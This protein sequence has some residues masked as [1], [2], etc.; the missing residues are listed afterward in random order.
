[1][2][3]WIITLILSFPASLAC[4]AD[5]PMTGN[6][7]LP[8]RTFGVQGHFGRHSEGW[9]IEK[10]L[11]IM[12]QMG[13]SCVKDEIYWSMVEKR[14]GVYEIDEANEKFVN[15]LRAAG[16][17][18]IFSLTY[19]NSLYADSLDAD[20]YAN[21]CRFM[22]SH[23]KGRVDIW[24]IW[25][26]PNNFEFKARYGGE[27]NGKNDSPWI[28]KFAIL[29]EK[30][31]RAIRK[32]NP[33]A[34]IITSAGN[35]PATH[36]LVTRFAS[37]LQD[38]DGLA[39]HP[40]PMRLPP[41]TLPYGGKEVNLRDGIVTADDDHS[42][43][44]TMR[45]LR[46]LGT[47]IRKDPSIWITE[48]GYTTYNQTRGT[49]PLFYGFTPEAQAAYLVR[50]V[51]QALADKVS[52][53]CLYDLKNDGQNIYEPEDN[54]GLLNFDHSP[55]PAALAFMRLAR[56]LGGGHEVLT[57][58]PAKMEAVLKEPPSSDVW[59][60]GPQEPFIQI[61]GPQCHWF[62][63][64]SGI[65][66]VFWKAGR[67]NTEINMPV[68]TFS[69]PEYKGKAPDHAVDLVTGEKTPL[70]CLQVKS[71]PQIILWSK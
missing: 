64:A 57:M 50:M 65:V 24:E 58:P 33:Q 34:T 20:A 27:W 68:V 17:K 60:I 66:A 51:V 59:Q 2:P 52:A 56:I 21:Y 7:P 14:K 12:R 62:K 61:N 63:T 35:P 32:A 3:K 42:F 54:F 18:P 31:A 44:S 30:A 45:R 13:V 26:E 48:V 5:P 43:F 11:P 16:I 38:I 28:D 47:T 15:A 25:N 10:L 8:I 49:N 46:Q 41:E 6:Y 22:A 53:V 40:Y 37:R 71:N 23:F 36:Y 69:W 4:M 39:E 29:V 55:K 1:M 19:G 67:Y 9:D 70:S